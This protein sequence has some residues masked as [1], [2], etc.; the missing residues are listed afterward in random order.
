MGYQLIS[1]SK[2]RKLALFIAEANRAKKF[3][4]VSREFLDAVETNV[5]QF[6]QSRVMH[7]PSKGKTLG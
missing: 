6:V 5:R 2:V 4:R 7:H 1:P 3:T